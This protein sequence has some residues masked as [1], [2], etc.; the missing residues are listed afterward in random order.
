MIPRV[1]VSTPDLSDIEKS[2]LID[3]FDSGWISANGKYSQEFEKSWARE[4]GSEYSLLVANGTVALHLILASLNIG[5]GDEVIVPTF[6]YIASVNS[7]KYVG[8]TPVFCDADPGTW[9]LDFEMAKSKITPKTK[10]I[11]FVHLY[12][13]PS[14][15]IKF[16][17]LCDDR[18][19]TLIED[20]AEAPFANENGRIAGSI[21]HVASF[22]FFGNK[23]ISSGE[24]GAVTTTNF[25]LYERMKLLRDQGMSLERRYYFPAIGFNFR[26][27]NLQAAILTGQLERKT[28]MMA[29]RF[30]V[31]ET[32]TEVLRNSASVEFQ[33]VAPNTVA[34]PWLFS[35]RLKS[36]KLSISELSDKL[37][38]VGIETRPLFIPIHLMPPYKEYANDTFPVAESLNSTGI[39]L[40]TSS[41]YNV[42]T[43]REIAHEV[44]S[45]IEEKTNE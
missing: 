3:A 39:S 9:N 26:I 16:R 14:G 18:G 27:T 32:Y 17:E 6:T 45:W 15:S 28:E 23:I 34:S 1:P 4:T 5:P 24:G 20:A 35:I 29:A 33:R 41:T 22:S 37:S 40:P 11:I 36:P 31:V 12:G 25:K 42:T 43:I 30:K 13:N 8:A 2:K 19:V 21:G 10:A 38:S 44:L 7:I